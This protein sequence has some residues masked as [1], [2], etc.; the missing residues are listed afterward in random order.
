MFLCMKSRLNLVPH[1]WTATYLIGRLVA[2]AIRTQT[3]ARFVL[4]PPPHTV[5]RRLLAALL[6]ASLGSEAAHR[7]R[8]AFGPPQRS[9]QRRRRAAR[10][11]LSHDV[12][13]P[14]N[15]SH[16]SA[17]AQR[18]VPVPVGAAGLSRPHH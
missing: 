17:P 2:G 14:A 16:A 8:T 13:N 10:P 15:R 9:L 4:L 11:A 18:S 6:P 7:S 5:C 12:G 1:A 3:S